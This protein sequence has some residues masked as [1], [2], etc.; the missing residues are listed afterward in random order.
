MQVPTWLV[1]ATVTPGVAGCKDAHTWTAPLDNQLYLPNILPYPFLIV[2]LRRFQSLQW[3]L[4]RLTLGLWAEGPAFTPTGISIKA[5]L[6]S[7]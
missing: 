2:S 6:Y 7:I 1:I 4:G 5:A 3:Y